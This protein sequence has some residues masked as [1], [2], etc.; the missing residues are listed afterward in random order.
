MKTLTGAMTSF[1][2]CLAACAAAQAA[3]AGPEPVVVRLRGEAAVPSRLLTVGDVAELTGGVPLLRDNLAR[4]DLT[5]VPRDRSSVTVT[6][7]QLLYRMKLSGVPEE[8][9]RV[10]GRESIQV[11]LRIRPIRP[12]EVVAEA[13]KALEARLPWPPAEVVI[14]L[15]GPVTAPLPSVAGDELVIIKAELHPGQRPVGRVQMDVRVF[16]QGEVRLSLPVLFQVR[17]CTK[18]VV[19]R[20]RVEKGEA[21]DDSS[22]YLEE[23]PVDQKSRYA[24]APEAVKGARARHALVP[25]QVILQTDVEAGEK[26]SNAVLVRAQESVKIQIRIGDLKV[27]AAGQALQ[28]GRQGQLIRVQNV[29]SKKLLLGR[30]VAAGLVEVE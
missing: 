25:G 19:C 9:F 14:D 20:R 1:W 10:E 22:V 6:R 11:N 13:R 26:P 4:L 2:I 29:D 24:L 17:P 30:V 15:V 21:L 23:Q 27:T 18:T 8:L 16:V 12:E 28:E 7:K 3:Q 5:D